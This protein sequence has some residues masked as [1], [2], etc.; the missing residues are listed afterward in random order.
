M[1]QILVL[2]IS[3]T[4]I[5]TGSVNYRIAIN[6]CGKMILVVIVN[7]KHR[8]DSKISLRINLVAY[9]FTSDDSTGLENCCGITNQKFQSGA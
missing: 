4:Q 8:M 9:A 1:R 3:D 5:D 2:S 6:I 7:F